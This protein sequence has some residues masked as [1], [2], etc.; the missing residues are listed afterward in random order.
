MRLC[1]TARM[2]YIYI[3]YTYTYIY[4]CWLVGCVCMYGVYAF[5]Q[6]ILAQVVVYSPPRHFFLLQTQLVLVLCDIAM[7]IAK[8]SPVR[9]NYR[10]A[11]A[12]SN[13]LNRKENAV[14]TRLQQQFA[15]IPP[16]HLLACLLACMRRMCGD[17]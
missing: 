17:V 8:T 4:K 1:C 14:G 2:V 11:T 12:V 3:L 15:L 6:H 10:T 13:C 5:R 7:P 16:V 9:R